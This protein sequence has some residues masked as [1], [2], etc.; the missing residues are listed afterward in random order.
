[1][2]LYNHEGELVSFVPALT[3][4]STTKTIEK[5]EEVKSNK[6]IYNKDLK[7][8]PLQKTELKLIPKVTTGTPGRTDGNLFIQQLGTS[9]SNVTEGFSL[10]LGRFGVIKRDV[11]D[12]VCSQLAQDLYALYKPNL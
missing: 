3:V 9:G 12:A 7:S 10:T 6:N 11:G 8:K 1:M 2:Y 4:T 5:K